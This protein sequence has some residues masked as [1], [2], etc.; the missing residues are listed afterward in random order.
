MRPYM[1]D[2]MLFQTYFLSQSLCLYT[3]IDV[4]FNFL[5]INAKCDICNTFYFAWFDVYLRETEYSVS[6]NT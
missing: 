5:N 2:V 3:E 1:C 6:E 4:R